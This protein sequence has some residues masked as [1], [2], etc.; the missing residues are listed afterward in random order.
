L[1]T[2]LR[3]SAETV[4]GYSGAPCS[5]TNTRPP[6]PSHHWPAASCSATCPLRCSRITSTVPASMLTTPGPVALGRAVDPFTVDDVGG[7]PE[8]HLGG[9]EVDVGPAEM[10]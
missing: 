4:L 9:V 5:A 6:S 8:G 2:S 7:T 10:E 1:A 3:I